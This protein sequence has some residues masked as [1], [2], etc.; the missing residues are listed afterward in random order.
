MPQTNPETANVS[1]A[2]FVPRQLTYEEFLREYDG[3]YAEYLM[4]R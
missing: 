3:Q 1:P 4:I 2:R